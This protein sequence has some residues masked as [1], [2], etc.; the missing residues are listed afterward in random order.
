M[1]AIHMATVLLV[2]DQTFNLQLL[3]VLL[4]ANGYATVSTKRGAQALVLAAEQRPDII[5]L[6]IQMPGMDGF[7][8]ARQLKANPNTR[9]I[10]VIMV[11]ALDDRYSRLKA[12]EIGAEEFLTRPVDRSELLI[13]VRNLLRLKE[14]ADFVVVHNQRLEAQV[15]VRTLQLAESHRE[16][17]YTLALAAEYKDENTGSHVTRVSYYCRAIAESIGMDSEFRDLIFYASPMHDIGKIGIPDHILLKPGS[18]LTDEWEIMKTHAALGAKILARG[19][20]PYLLMGAEIALNHHERWD[21]GGYPNGKCGE[22]IPLCARLMSLVDQYDALRSKRPY[23][24]AFD[25]G[26]TRGIITRGDER[27]KPGHFDPDVLAAFEACAETFREI[28]AEHMDDGDHVM[29]Q[30]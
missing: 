2:D 3:Q 6:D 11:T 20:S 15:A 21:G 14:Y 26:A 16:T 13:R 4:E 17:I 30:C 18:F 9:N 25:H 22:E 27:T 23:K 10:P 29:F 1:A 19:N 12:L 8:V 24:P 7:E 5:L 28:Y